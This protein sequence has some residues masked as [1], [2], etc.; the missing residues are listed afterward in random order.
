MRKFYWLCFGAVLLLGLSACLDTETDNLENLQVTLE[1]EGNL[2]LFAEAVSISPF[3]SV[4]ELGINTVFAPNNQAMEAFLS[5]QGYA[6]VSAIPDTTLSNLV[7]YHFVPGVGRSG[8]ISPDYYTTLS[9]QSPNNSGVSLLIEPTSTTL[10]LNGSVQGTRLDLEASNGVIHFIDAVLI[11]PGIEDIFSQNI[12]LSIMRNSL[13]D[14]GI[15]DSL[16]LGNIY[17]IITPPNTAFTNYLNE[18]GLGGI[19]DIADEEFQTLIL[20]HIIS[21]NYG[22]EELA[23]STWNTLENSLTVGVELSPGP[24]PEQDMYVVND[25]SSLLL[26]DV[27]ATDG[28]IQ[29]IDRILPTTR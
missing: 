15:F 8:E 11:P 29:I 28:I 21:G 18:R 14:L 22:I 10:V 19:S 9:N 7:G 16:T 6:S 26:G 27:Q 2:S 20:R 23:N 17:T 4:A 5:Q 12:S 13:Q 25:S 1:S 24:I 3:A